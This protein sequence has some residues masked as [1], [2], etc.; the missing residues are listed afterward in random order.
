MMAVMAIAEDEEGT[1][2]L[3]QLYFQPEE[4]TVPAGAYVR[5]G[6]TCILKDP[7]FKCATDGKYS[8]RVDHLTDVI[9]LD[10]G[11]D[12]VPLKWRN[13]VLALSDTSTN[14][15]M[16]GNEAVKKDEWFEAARL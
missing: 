1:A 15:R 16:R 10:D 11:D 6:A 8:L 3:L 9:W 7:F 5:P 4:S 12:R 14:F 13:P 2:V